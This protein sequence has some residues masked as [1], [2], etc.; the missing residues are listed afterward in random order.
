MN[1]SYLFGRLEI[2][3]WLLI[4]GTSDDPLKYDYWALLDLKGWLNATFLF[5]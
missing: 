2:R 4:I 5:C 3:I 1:F